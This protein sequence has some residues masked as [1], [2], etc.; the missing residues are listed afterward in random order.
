MTPELIAA[1]GGPCACGVILGIIHWRT[2]PRIAK[3]Q[4]RIAR[5]FAD[6]LER[7]RQSHR[8]EL[9]SVLDAHRQ[10]NRHIAAAIAGQAKAL[11]TNTLEAMRQTYELREMRRGHVSADLPPLPEPTI[12]V[13]VEQ[14]VGEE[15]SK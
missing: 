11:Q 15:E 1:L 2:A 3:A 4:E 7:E 9:R 5:Q 6:Q 14:M 12:T 10:D 13:D 8:E